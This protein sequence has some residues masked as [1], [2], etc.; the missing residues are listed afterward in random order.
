VLL[1]ED[2]EETRELLQEILQQAG[3]PTCLARDAEEALALLAR[4]TFGIVVLDLVLPGVFD[5]WRFLREMRARRASALLPVVVISA[6]PLRE[7]LTESL[8]DFLSKPFSLE[9]FL[10]CL[11]R[12]SVTAA[13]H[14]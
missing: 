6:W 3:Y 13:A 8:V 1:V 2:D 5:G 4:E 12:V 7:P 14:A 10:Q 11:D 9:E